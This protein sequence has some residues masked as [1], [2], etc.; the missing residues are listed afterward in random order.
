LPFFFG[1]LAENFIFTAG[2]PIETYDIVYSTPLVR[3]DFEANCCEAEP[4][5]FNCDEPGLL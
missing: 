2:F 1:F 3:L 5:F 4:D